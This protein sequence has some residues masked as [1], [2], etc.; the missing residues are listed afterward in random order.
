[1]RGW[2]HSIF[3]Y[4]HKPWPLGRWDWLHVCWWR[5]AG[6]LESWVLWFA[7]GKREINVVW[8][9]NMRIHTGRHC[10]YLFDWLYFSEC[11]LGKNQQVNSNSIDALDKFT[12]AW[13]YHIGQIAVKIL[14]HRERR[15]KKEIELREKTER[16]LLVTS[17]SGA[18]DQMEMCLLCDTRQKHEGKRRQLI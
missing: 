2:Q 10:F 5:S 16:R 11:F 17:V 9:W 3:R 1:M 18:F 14:L 15:E 7:E 13:R 8:C 12:T 6:S 4:K